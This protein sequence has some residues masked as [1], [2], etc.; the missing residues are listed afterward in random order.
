MVPYGQATMQTLLCLW[1]LDYISSAS[2]ENSDSWNTKDYQK[3]EH[4][5]TKPYHHGG[6][7]GRPLW[8]FGGTAMITPNYVRLTADKQGSKGYIWNSVPVHLRSWEMHVHFKVWS[9]N[10]KD[11]F[12][13]GFALW[14][15]KERMH[16]GK[17][18]RH[19][20]IA[21]EDSDDIYI[22]VHP[23]IYSLFQTSI[24]KFIY[25]K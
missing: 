1:I 19:L 14:Y 20:L 23:F 17:S 15:A 5:L 4:C 24:Q 3:R 9:Q 11:L 10:K 2:P 21:R 22:F 12:G 7:G 8:D 6:A 16:Q 18:L 13:D 25:C